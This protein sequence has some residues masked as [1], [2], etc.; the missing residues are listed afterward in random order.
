[1]QQSVMFICFVA[2]GFF[3]LTT[4]YFAIGWIILQCIYSVVDSVWVISSL[5]LLKVILINICFPQV[6]VVIH[7]I[8]LI[9]TS[10]KLNGNPLQISRAFSHSQQISPPHY[11]TLS[12][13]KASTSLDCQSCLLV[14]KCTCNLFQSGMVKWQT[15]KQTVLKEKLVTYS[16]QEGRG[17]CRTRQ[18]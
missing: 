17:T 15:W 3:I 12:K 18:G 6:L 5:G 10:L 7:M 1:M 16:S 9:N 8:V 11:F 4:L 2:C 13:T 14:L